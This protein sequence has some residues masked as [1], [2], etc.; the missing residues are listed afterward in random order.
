MTD[1]SPYQVKYTVEARQQYADIDLDVISMTVSV[2]ADR[3]NFTEA[4]MVIAS[5]DNATW[6]A[7]DPRDEDG[8]VGR[9][10][11]FRIKQY[12][13]DD[14]ELGSLPPA[15]VISGNDWGE[16]FIRTASRDFMTG[17]VTL[18]LASGESMMTDKVSI[19]DNDVDTGAT[20]VY[21]LLEYCLNNVFGGAAVTAAGVV[22][23]TPIPAGER[24]LRMIGENMLDVVRAELDA[25]ECRLSDYFGRL[26]KAELRNGAGITN[27]WR[28]A[29]YTQA[30][31]MPTNFDPIVTEFSQTLSREGDWADG[32]LATFDYTTAAGVRTVQHQITG[33]GANTKGFVKRYDR[34]APGGNTANKLLVRTQIRGSEVT[35]RARN[36]FDML[37]YEELILR[38]RQGNLTAII[39]SIEW[40]TESGEMTVR[41]QTGAP[42]T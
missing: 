4:T 37:P 1:P 30:E 6:A 27:E 17:Q 24:R 25:I 9:R 12:D 5:V 18:T 14:N 39:R 38:T 2:D 41:A 20:N 36:R 23:S 15:S 11:I 13:L 7:L 32:V 29:T 8:L 34:A 16:L 19:A 26:W 28:L 22:L 35:L 10:V 42:I 33:G 40:D 31:G 21:E 3:V